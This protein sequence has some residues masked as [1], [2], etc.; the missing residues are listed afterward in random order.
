MFLIIV[1]DMSAV[2]LRY[3]GFENL[4]WN[5]LEWKYSKLQKSFSVLSAEEGAVLLKRFRTKL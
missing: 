3:F 1:R 2:F 4:H 5:F